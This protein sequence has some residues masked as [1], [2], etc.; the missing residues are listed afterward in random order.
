MNWEI[1]FRDELLKQAKGEKLLSALEVGI[2]KA[3]KMLGKAKGAV[4]VRKA[5]GGKTG[6]AMAAAAG[7]PVKT[8]TPLPTARDVGKAKAEAAAAEA[9]A[10]PKAAPGA[11]APAV[12]TGKA[13]TKTTNT[14]HSTGWLVGTGAAGLGIG[15]AAGYGMGK[16]G[17]V[18][19]DLNKSAARSFIIDAETN[20]ETKIY[21]VRGGAVPSPALL[22]TLRYHEAGKM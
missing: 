18:I 5:P 14:G 7:A 2:A 20:N 21:D 8:T 19:S 12:P 17:S 15:A 13:N 16:A 22:P 10:A 6:K 4:R 1:S 3:E 11:P 9:A